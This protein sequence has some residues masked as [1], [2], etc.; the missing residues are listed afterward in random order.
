MASIRAY[1]K[2]LESL[3]ILLSVFKDK[4]TVK[5]L[6]ACREQRLATEEEVKELEL[7]IETTL[8]AMVPLGGDEVAV[9]FEENIDVNN[10]K[11]GVEEYN[12]YSED[13]LWEHL[14]LL[15]KKLPFS[16]CNLI[17]MPSLT[18]GA[19]MKL[20]PRWHQLVSILRMID[21]ALDCEPGTLQEAWQVPW[22][23]CSTPS[24]KDWRQH[25]RLAHCDHVPPNLQHQWM[26]EIQQYLRRA[27]FDVLPYTGKYVTQVQWWTM[28]WSQCQQPP[29]RHIIL[30]TT[31][32]VQ[33]DAGTIVILPNT[34][35][36]HEDIM[37]TVHEGHILCNINTAHT[38]ARALQGKS[39]SI[40]IMTATPVT[41]KPADLWNMGLLL[42]L[43]TFKDTAQ[44]K[45][46]NRELSAAQ[47]RDRNKILGL[48]PYDHSLKIKLLDWEMENLR[49]IACGYLDDCPIVGMSK[50]FY[51]EFRR[52]N[53]HL[54]MNSTKE[55]SWTKPKS[56]EEWDTSPDTKSMKLERFSNTIWSLT[57]ISH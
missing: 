13:D 23:I 26:S 43:Q 54:H 25:S 7:L 45:T 46:M 30:A 10:W 21:R 15:E 50:N 28:A 33:D 16:R 35:F 32:A 6:E 48:P 52:S 41:T 27:T 39:H 24:Q 17:P 20:A 19:K 53:L 22:K 4:E 38:A 47:R 3:V 1:L 12:R 37:N 34:L 42:G 31:N 57:V 9:D 2:K 18:H 55:W 49:N 40:A 11:S 8:A 36:G 29:I 14:G 44:L 56:W 51:V 5:T